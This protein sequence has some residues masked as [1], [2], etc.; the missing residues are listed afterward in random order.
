MRYLRTIFR[1]G[2]VI[3][4]FGL[5]G[6]VFDDDFDAVCKARENAAGGGNPSSNSGEEARAATGARP[7]AAP[8]MFIT[9][10][11]VRRKSAQPVMEP[12][13]DNSRTTRPRFLASAYLRKAG[14]PAGVRSQRPGKTVDERQPRL[15]IVLIPPGV[16]R[17]ARSRRPKM[18][19]ISQTPRPLGCRGLP[20]RL[21]QGEAR[22]RRCEARRRPDEPGRPGWIKFPISPTRALGPPGEDEKG[23]FP[24]LTAAYNSLYGRLLCLFSEQ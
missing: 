23:A 7:A 3:C 18:A 24:L 10:Q 20:T 13:R 14:R 6:C 8:A 5:T 12:E 2:L 19:P 4:L 21:R 1:A 17:R 9:L 15:R 11:Q 16:G 22:L